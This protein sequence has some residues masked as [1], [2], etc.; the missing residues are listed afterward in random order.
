NQ[1][2]RSTVRVELRPGLRRLFRLPLESRT[3]IHADIDEELDA[4]ITARIEELT[5]RGASYAEAREEALRRLGMNLDEARQHLHHSA[6][7]RERRMRLTDLAES[8][9]QDVRYAVRGLVRR[10]ALTVVA[11]LTLAVGIGATTAIFSAVEALLLRALPYA[12]P[13]ELMT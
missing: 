4:L 6:E 7:Y 8:T 12:H 11:G 3:A 1:R 2:R 5:R 9:M 13:D 10:P